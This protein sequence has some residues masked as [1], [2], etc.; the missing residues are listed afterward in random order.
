MRLSY[1][2][3][4]YTTHPALLSAG[5][6][7]GKNAFAENWYLN[8][9]SR[10]YGRDFKEK[11]KFSQIPFWGA[12]IAGPSLSFIIKKP[13]FAYFSQRHGQ[14]CIQ[15]LS[16][17]FTAIFA[18]IDST[19]RRF[20]AP[21]TPARRKPRCMALRGRAKPIFCFARPRAV[22]NVFR[23]RHHCFCGR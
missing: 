20:A 9:T 7:C 17:A 16:A 11:G 6:A 19:F 13:A 5:V 4:L 23:C 10:I 12:E 8:H 18:S 22:R 1:F 21:R 14:F 15:Q 2:E 3:P